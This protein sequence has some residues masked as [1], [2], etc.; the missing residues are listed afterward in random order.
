MSGWFRPSPADLAKLIAEYEA[1]ASLCELGE[2]HDRRWTVI[3]RALLQAGVEL[4]AQGQRRKAVPE[5]RRMAHDYEKGATVLALEA[6]YGVK[7]DTI[8]RN[9]REQG[10]TIRP[11]GP[12]R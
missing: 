10:V 1:G 12:R 5:I 7:R 4:R 3:R 6:R 11:T 8:T 9:L 2:R